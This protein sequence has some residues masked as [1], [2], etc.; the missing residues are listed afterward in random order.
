MYIVY[1]NKKKY[2]IESQEHITNVMCKVSM[3][4][5]CHHFEVVT[6]EILDFEGHKYE[7]VD[8]SS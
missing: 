6:H 2:I 5:K 8:Y 3:T 1:C 4:L 7:E